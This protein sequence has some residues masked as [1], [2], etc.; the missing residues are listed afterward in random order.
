V[1]LAEACVRWKPADH[2]LLIGSA[3]NIFERRACAMGLD[4]SRITSAENHS[5]DQVIQN[6]RRRTGQS[7]M[8]MGMGNIAGPGFE[9]LRYFRSHAKKSENTAFQEV[10]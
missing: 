3:T 8:V 7:A 6:V 4:P 1:Q 2:Y 10:A 5:T 9:L